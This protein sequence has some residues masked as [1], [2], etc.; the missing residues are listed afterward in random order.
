MKDEKQ[1]KPKDKNDT[2]A[3]LERRIDIG[4]MRLLKAKRPKEFLQIALEQAEKIGR[5]AKS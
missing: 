4:M 5:P 3:A 1:N 2:Q